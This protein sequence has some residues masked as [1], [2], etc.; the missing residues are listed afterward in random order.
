MFE[1]ILRRIPDF[2]ID[3]PARQAPDER[4]YYLGSD[5]VASNIHA[6]VYR[7]AKRAAIWPPFWR[8]V[9]KGGFEPPT[10]GL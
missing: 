4:N 9:V 3:A 8:L 1:E 10:Y 7:L 5:R 2:K 6:D